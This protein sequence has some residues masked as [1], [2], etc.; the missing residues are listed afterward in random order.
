MEIKKEYLGHKVY[1]KR[2]ERNVIV[3]QENVHFFSNIKWLFNEV[4]PVKDDSISTVEPKHGK[5][6][7][8]R[9]S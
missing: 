4:K 2:L 7:T 6:R 1:I 9:K 3:C 5:R 8:K